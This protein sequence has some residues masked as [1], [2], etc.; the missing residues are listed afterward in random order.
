MN[1]MPT[2]MI[3]VLAIKGMNTDRIVREALIYE[4]L[5]G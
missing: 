4:I 2:F 5:S 1:N 3:D